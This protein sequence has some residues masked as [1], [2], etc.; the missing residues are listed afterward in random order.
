MEGERVIEGERERD[1]EWLF[2]HEVQDKDA[3]SNSFISLITHDMAKH[4]RKQP[5]SECATLGLRQN[6][7]L[8]E[9]RLLGD[10]LYF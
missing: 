1:K 8:V 4:S 5:L 2:I 6:Y 10:Q 7:L 9:L 3:G